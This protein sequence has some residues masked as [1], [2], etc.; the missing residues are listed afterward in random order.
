MIGADTECP[1]LRGLLG[2]NSVAAVTI[3]QALHW[4][5]PRSLFRAIIP[6]VRP[7]GGVAVVTNGTPLWL[8]DT[9]WS[10]ALRDHLEHWLDTKLTFACGTDEQSQ[11]R[12]TET[13]LRPGSM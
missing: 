8:Q 3:G 12:Y 5:E 6:L 11:R 2:D 9:D 10:R 7:G 13:W 1:A 4:M